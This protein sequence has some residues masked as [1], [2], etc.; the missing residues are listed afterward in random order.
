[1]SIKK[2]LFDP[3]KSSINPKH[4]PFNNHVK[5]YTIL[6]FYRKSNVTM[7][8]QPIEINCIMYLSIMSN[9][10][11][12]KIVSSLYYLYEAR[13]VLQGN[14]CGYYINNDYMCGCQIYCLH[15]PLT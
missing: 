12:F 4:V 15:F 3:F 11:F 7:N 10:N 2:D 14:F 5:T 9:E 13:R 8:Y 6:Y 1:M